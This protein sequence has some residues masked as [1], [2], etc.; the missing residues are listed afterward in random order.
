[1]PE[2][3]QTPQESEPVSKAAPSRSTHRPSSSTSSTATCGD[4]RT[5]RNT[6]GRRTSPGVATSSEIPSWASPGREDGPRPLEC[7]ERDQDLQARPRRGEYLGQPELGRL[8]PRDEVV[9]Y[10]SEDVEQ[11]RGHVLG[12]GHPIVVD[13]AVDRPSIRV[14]IVGLP[15]SQASRGVRS[16]RDQSVWLL[17]RVP[18]LA[19]DLDDECVRLSL[20]GDHPLEPQ[21]PWP[22]ERIENGEFV[23]RH[24]DGAG[25]V[26]APT[27][28]L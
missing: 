27:K 17:R 26:H 2:S 14:P 10:P 4:V 9:V 12:E 6:S 5:A 24:V 11:V 18:V 13:L 1:M 7:I 25:A 8:D 22:R 23:V 15:E 19:R 16:P 20:C 21:V 3:Q 28:S